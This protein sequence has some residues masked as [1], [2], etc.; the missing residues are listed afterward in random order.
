MAIGAAAAAPAEVGLG[1][2]C[3]C[4]VAGWRAEVT[5]PAPIPEM[6]TV[7]GE[8]GE[9]GGVSIFGRFSGMSLIVRVGSSILE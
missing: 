3:C 7:P 4:R 2:F 1:T 5:L 9:V 6:L 8:C